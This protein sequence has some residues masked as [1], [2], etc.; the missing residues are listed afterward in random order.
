[1]ARLNIPLLLT[2]AVT[3]LLTLQLKSCFTPV[4]KPEEMVRNEE[5]IKYL[6][7]Q[8]ITDS[9][10]LV[11]TREKYDSLIFISLLKVSSFEIQK[12]PIRYAIKQVPVIVG[13]YD[14]EQLRRA[15][16]GY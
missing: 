10:E 11:D 2:I 3:V 15:L 16:S 5:R 8:R 12:Q 9:V 13:N 6:E 14:K 4:R 7:A 1:M